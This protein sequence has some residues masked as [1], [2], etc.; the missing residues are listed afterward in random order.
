M[1]V[2]EG[3]KE[4]TT[5]TVKTCTQ[6][7]LHIGWTNKLSQVVHIWTESEELTEKQ[8]T[9]SIARHLNNSSI[10]FATHTQKEGRKKL[11]VN[12]ISYPLSSTHST[13]KKK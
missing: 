4:Q 12:S 3:W 13:P 10:L 6:L 11:C 5:L 2:D 1:K 9:E 8:T 7:R